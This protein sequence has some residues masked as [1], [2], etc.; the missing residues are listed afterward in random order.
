MIPVALVKEYGWS[1]SVLAG[2]FCAFTLLHRAPAHRPAPQA[3]AGGW[4]SDRTEREFIH[5]AG[6]GVMVA[7]VAALAVLGAGLAGLVRSKAG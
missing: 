6:I 7:A 5:L 4:L 2:A 1:R 3:A